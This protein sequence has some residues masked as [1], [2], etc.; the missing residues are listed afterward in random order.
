V[1]SDRSVREIGDEAFADC[2]N[3]VKVT[4][5]FVEEVGEGAFEAGYTLRHV[6]L[7]R[8]IV[9]KPQ[10]FLYCA[11]LDVISESAGFKVDTG[12]K[13]SSGR[14]D[15]TFGITRF[16]KWRTQMDDNKEYYKIAMVMIKLC[17]TPITR[18]RMRAST[19]DPLWAFM[20]RSGRDLAKHI[21]SFRLGVKVGKGDLREASKEKL[22]EVGL[23][24]KVLRMENNGWS[25]MGC[26][27]AVVDE[28]GKKI[29]GG[30]REAVRRELVTVASYDNWW[31]MKK[32]YGDL[33]DW[34]GV[35]GMPEVLY[36]RF[37]DGVAMP[38]EE[39]LFIDWSDED[40]S[41]DEEDFDEEDY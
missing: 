13:T 29:D 18:S 10:V 30:I 28:E 12:E 2:S 39:G 40:N 6:I 34:Y 14:N 20:A 9:V 27:G 16:A 4:A 41:S 19:N 3:I 36:G 35:Y 31:G 23:E 11:L 7:R 5:P 32:G 22:L 1:V 15:P 24:L 33:I 38:V 37:V 21:L 8:N 25:N 26:Y 17:N